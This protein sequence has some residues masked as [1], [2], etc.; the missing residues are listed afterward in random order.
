G[1]GR[2]VTESDQVYLDRTTK[3]ILGS[4][5][6]SDAG[7][8]ECL[9]DNGIAPV[10]TA[11]AQLIVRFKPEIQKGVHLSKEAVAGD[12]ISTATLNCK[13]EGIPDV[14][15][16]WAKNGV[17][18]DSNN[19]RY[20]QTTLHEGP[21]HTAQLNI[22][23]ASAS[24]DYATFTCTAQNPL[25]LDMFDIH[26]V[27]TGRPDPPTGL[28][29]MRKTHNSLTLSWGAG[30]NGGLEQ[31]FQIRYIAA[32]SL[33]S[34]YADVYLAQASSFT[35]TG[36]RPLTTY[37]VSVRAINALGS[38][39][40]ADSG[41]ALSV[42]TSDTGVPDPFPTKAQFIPEQIP[43]GL[44]IP[45]PLLIPLLSLALLLLFA[46]IGIIVG[47]IRRVR[48]RGTGKDTE[49]SAS[50]QRKELNDYA[51]DLVNVTSRRTLLIDTEPEPCSTTYESFDGST[52]QA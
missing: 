9:A 48:Q 7:S 22:I 42:T 45:L 29:V 13:A 32:G 33:S 41:I 11:R 49:K 16:Y 19:P 4:A 47:L 1:E 38:S 25:G 10:S 43:G 46:N 26:L 5:M 20:L 12:G 44:L 36:L 52:S 39:D 27:S 6:R 18:L 40:Y 23:N 8:Y 14:E 37:N 2:K 21:L 3:L 50:L 34:L 31:T 35:L 51:D 28:A 30:F 15:F 17:A 24:L